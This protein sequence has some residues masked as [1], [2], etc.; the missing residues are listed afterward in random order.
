MFNLYYYNFILIIFLRCELPQYTQRYIVCPACNCIV[1]AIKTCISL[2]IDY[3]VE[4]V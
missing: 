4:N 3:S 2:M 1:P